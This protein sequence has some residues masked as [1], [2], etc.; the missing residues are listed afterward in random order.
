MLLLPAAFP[1]HAQRSLPLT[2]DERSGMYCLRGS[3]ALVNDRGR[4]TAEQAELVVDL[5][6]AMLLALFTYKPEVKKFVSRARIPEL[7]GRIPAG[8]RLPVLQPA[9][10]TFLD[11]YT[12]RGRPVL[13]LENRMRLP[14]HGFL[15]IRFFERFR[16]IFDFRRAQLRITEPSPADG[17][18]LSIG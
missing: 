6:N 12:F 4:R 14:G 2:R 7:E 10:V 5:G 16:V 11:A 1:A 9:A 15:G 13:L 17:A 18:D 8:K 3:L